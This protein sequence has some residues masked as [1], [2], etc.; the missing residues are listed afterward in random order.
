VPP[1]RIVTAQ[2]LVANVPTPGMDR[3]EAVSG[4]ARIIAVRTEPGLVFRVLRV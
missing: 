2:D 4:D 3:R 1:I